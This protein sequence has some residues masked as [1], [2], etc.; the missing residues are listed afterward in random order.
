MKTIANYAMRYKGMMTRVTEFQ[1][2]KFNLMEYIK[3]PL[4]NMRKEL[5]LH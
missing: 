1:K 2:E 3:F 5:K 4:T